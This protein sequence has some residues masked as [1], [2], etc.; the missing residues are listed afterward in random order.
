MFTPYRREYRNISLLRRSEM[1]ATASST[2]LN[3]SLSRPAFK[4][5]SAETN[6]S[7]AMYTEKEEGTKC[8]AMRESMMRFFSECSS[9][10]RPSSIFPSISGCVSMYW[11]SW[12][13][14][15]PISVAICR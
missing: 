1:D 10:R 7:A 11:L 14:V 2:V 15:M 3:G 4:M 12:R 13:V 5:R 9:A 6:G 8:H